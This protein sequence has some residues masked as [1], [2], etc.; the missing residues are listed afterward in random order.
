MQNEIFGVHYDLRYK[1]DE[2][3]KHIAAKIS[4]LTEKALTEEIVR[5]AR[6]AGVTD[7]FLMDKNFLLSAIREKQERTNPKLLTLDELRQMDGDKIYIQYIGAC[8][9]FYDDEYA[10]YYGQNE[11][12][13]QKYNGMLRACDLPLKYYGKTWIAYRH[14]PEEELRAAQRKHAE[15]CL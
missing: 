4:D 10:P 8:K 7:L 3:S 12:Y 2:L 1:G 5:T 9:G 6:K 14:K 11:Q 15:E 13:V